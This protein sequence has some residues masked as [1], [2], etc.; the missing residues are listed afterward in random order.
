MNENEIQ[1]A[2]NDRVVAEEERVANEVERIE[3][4]G[5]VG[6]E[7]EEGRVQ[8]EAGRVDAEAARVI[9]DDARAKSVQAMYR[10]VSVLIALPIA[11]IA[12]IPAVVGL[13]ALSR[14]SNAR[15]V[16]ASENRDA[17]RTTIIGTLAPLGYQIDETGVAVPTAEGPIEYYKT[18][19]DERQAALQAT[20]TSLTKAFPPITC[21]GGW[22]S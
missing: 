10:R 2:E 4:E 21:D 1:Q 19:E 9:A 8:A 12:L 11:F 14:E 13:I 16:D 22:F 3:A 18:H 20:L 5:A 7:P 17:I 6:H 15:C